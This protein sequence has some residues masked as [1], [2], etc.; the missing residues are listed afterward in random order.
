MSLERKMQRGKVRKIYAHELV[1]STA[2]GMAEELFESM[3]S[4]DNEMFAEFKRESAESGIEPEAIRAAFV[5]MMLPKLLGQARATL[6]TMLG[7]RQF[8]HCHEQ[9]YE[10]LLR[11][12][13]FLPARNDD[14]K[15]D[16]LHVA[17]DGS[18][19]KTRH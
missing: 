2:R 19:T 14:G 18:V 5:E 8:A 15:R 7:Q 9:I 6:A 11:D 4:S 13:V 16:R 3:L 1:A 10:A 17:D 12:A